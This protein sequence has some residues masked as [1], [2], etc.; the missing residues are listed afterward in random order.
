[1]AS[2]KEGGSGLPSSKRHITGAP[3]APIAT[4]PWLE[5]AQATAEHRPP[6]RVMACLSG[7]QRGNAM[8]KQAC[9]QASNH[10]GPAA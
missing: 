8:E 1:M 4:T 6:L 2:S 3:P 9:R 7:E 10:R 5:G